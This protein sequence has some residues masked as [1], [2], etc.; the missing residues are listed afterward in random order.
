[1]FKVQAGTPYSPLNATSSP[2]CLHYVKSNQAS[3]GVIINHAAF[4]K[5]PV[6]KLT[7]G[8]AMQ[9]KLEIAM[10]LLTRNIRLRKVHCDVTFPRALEPGPS[11]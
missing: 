4:F 8:K 10:H 7:H 1:M 6:K 3:T 5:F 9:P 2:T 11:N